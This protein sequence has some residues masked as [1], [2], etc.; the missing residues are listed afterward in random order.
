MK[1]IEKILKEK[2]FRICENEV[3]SI[4]KEILKA[5]DNTIDKFQL[6]YMKNQE[7]D[8]L[9]YQIGMILVEYQEEYMK[10]KHQLE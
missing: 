9:R 2:H 4:Q 5:I 8:Q 3:T 7:N 6:V 10:L 1:A